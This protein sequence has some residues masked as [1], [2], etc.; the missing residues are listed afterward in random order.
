MT[1][2][3]RLSS[4]IITM[5]GKF[6]KRKQ[7]DDH[8]F[9]LITGYILGNSSSDRTRIHDSILT[10][11]QYVS[12]VLKGHEISCK[13]EFR[14]EKVIF[15]KLVDCL[16][17]KNLLRDTRGVTVEEQVAIFIYAISKNASNRD[18]QW[19]FQHSSETI[20]RHFGGSTKCN[21]PV[22]WKLDT[23]ATGEYSTQDLK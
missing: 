16:R 20:S 8:E 21:C 19:R 23:I 18:L 6:F 1:T 11:E 10:G 22:Y 13:R 15:H 17:E 14:M 4:P 5:W 12:E 3:P 9:A 7:R 2:R